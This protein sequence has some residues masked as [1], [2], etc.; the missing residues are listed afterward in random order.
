MRTMLW[1]APMI[2]IAA[3]AGAACATRKFVTDANRKK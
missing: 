1:V 3:I 2:L